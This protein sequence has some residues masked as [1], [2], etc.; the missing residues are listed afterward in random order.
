MVAD[1][2][3]RDFQVNDIESTI[4]DFIVNDLGRAADRDLRIDTPLLEDDLLDS[5]GVYE[6]VVHLE[7]RY[8]IEIVD[9]EMVPENFGTIATLTKLVESKR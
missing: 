2:R 9:E 4:R 5:V 3:L 6:L 8:D 1:L 7:A